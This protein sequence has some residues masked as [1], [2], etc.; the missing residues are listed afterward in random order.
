[1]II[2]EIG[3]GPRSHGGGVSRSQM[4]IQ[5]QI[6]IQLHIKR[7]KYSRDYRGNWVQSTVTRPEEEAKEGSS[8]LRLSTSDSPF[9]ATRLQLSEPNTPIACMTKCCKTTLETVSMPYI[10]QN[11]PYHMYI[12]CSK[13]ISKDI[14]KWLNL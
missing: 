13:L 14:L 4:Q 3:L 9:L 10:L 8:C 2:G 7:Q 5:T 1:M 6:Q 12:F 11:T